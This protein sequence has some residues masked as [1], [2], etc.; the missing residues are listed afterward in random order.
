MIVVPPGDSARPERGASERSGPPLHRGPRPFEF[1]AAVRRVVK[2]SAE[3]SAGRIGGGGRATA[4]GDAAADRSGDPGR[5]RAGVAFLSLHQR[6]DRLRPRCVEPHGPGRPVQPDAGATFPAPPTRAA[7]DRPL[8]RV[9]PAAAEP[10]GAPRPTA[11]GVGQVGAAQRAPGLEG[12]GHRV[13]QGQ[14]MP[15]ADANHR[16]AR[17]PLSLAASR[18]GQSL[19]RR[20]T[21]G[22]GTPRRSGRGGKSPPR[23]SRAGSFLPSWPLLPRRVVHHAEMGGA[24]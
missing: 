6:P 18:R 14:E 12:P 4:V 5:P 1:S 17:S 2:P 19:I 7:V 8:G 21:S 23:A 24:S 22:S 9:L 11:V 3:I 16:D 15:A 20:C 10:A 13:R